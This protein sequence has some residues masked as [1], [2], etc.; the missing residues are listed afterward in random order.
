[1][2]EGVAQHVRGDVIVLEAGG[3]GD[4]GDDVVRALLDDLY[5]RRGL[6]PANAA[7]AE[8]PRT[9][10]KALEPRAAVRF[11]RV[12]RL[13]IPR[14][15]ALARLLRHT[16]TG[17]AI[18]VQCMASSLWVCDQTAHAHRWPVRT[19]IVALAVTSPVRAAGSD[20][21]SGE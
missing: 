20:R 18:I 1:V 6:G 14:P 17:S 19:E 11:L 8:L 9:A 13:R 21:C 4:R 2:A 5:I 3:R 12:L 16:R 7:R 15:S 10:P